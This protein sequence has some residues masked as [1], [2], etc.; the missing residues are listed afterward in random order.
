MATALWAIIVVVLS[1]FIGALGQYF[2]KKAGERLKL[3]LKSIISDKYIYYGC[4]IYGLGAIIWILILP[5]GELSVLYPFIA[6]V[7]IW[8][9]VVSQK[10]FNEKMNL[11]K[12]LGIL[13]IILGVVCVG[14]GA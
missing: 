1:S 6:V 12:W 7:Y 14:F 3:S 11:W 5:Y 2:F 13:S 8:V 4:G 9:A 10:Y